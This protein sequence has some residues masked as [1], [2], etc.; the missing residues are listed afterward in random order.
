[1][2]NNAKKYC[3]IN[4]LINMEISVEMENKHP[5]KVKPK[6]AV[7]LLRGLH[8]GRPIDQRTRQ[9]KSVRAIKSAI[10]GNLDETATSLLESDA[11][12]SAVIQ[13][14]ALEQAFA[15]P[16]KII[17]PDGKDS[18]H[19]GT[20]RKYSGIQKIGT[21]GF[22]EIQ[23]KAGAGGKEETL[24]DMVLSVDEFNSQDTEL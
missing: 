2:C 10:R 16:T 21:L 17:G 23:T 5:K 11:A 3:Y 4:K 6:T 18:Y 22:K 19:L 15:D 8:Q 20:W 7:G 14:M 12:I 1:M 13:Q 9:A 24:A